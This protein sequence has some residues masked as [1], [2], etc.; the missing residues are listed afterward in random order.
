MTSDLARRRVL[1]RLV[2]FQTSLPERQWYV[3]RKDFQIIVLL[4]RFFSGK[5]FQLHGAILCPIPC[6]FNTKVNSTLYNSRLAGFGTYMQACNKQYC[7]NLIS[8]MW[9]SAFKL[10][11]HIMF[12]IFLVKYV[13]ILIFS[14]V[15]HYFIPGHNT[16]SMSVVAISYPV[17]DKQDRIHDQATKI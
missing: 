14:L 9:P 17:T 1:K 12:K 3:R 13:D 7:Q 16:L 11:A 4:T 5:S 10:L 6:V 8:V 2:S 15:C